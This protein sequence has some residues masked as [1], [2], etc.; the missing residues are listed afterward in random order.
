MAHDRGKI[1]QFARSYTE[2]WC[3]HEV[4]RIA[5]HFAPGGAIVFNGRERVGIEE[6]ANYFVAAF[7]DGEIF[8][9][10]LR[11]ED[12]SVE[13][14]WTLT[15]TRAETG[16]Q[17]RI[18]GYEEWTIGTD[19]LIAESQRHY[20]EAEYERQL[21]HVGLVGGHSGSLAQASDPRA[22]YLEH[23]PRQRRQAADLPAVRSDHG[24][25]GAQRRRD[26]RRRM[27]LPRV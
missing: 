10:D 11:F 14:H 20:D 5:D 12:G 2:A 24:S 9:D 6:V 25:R 15:G 27:G 21:Q 17:V 1:E 3:S 7:P 23:A 16:K 4:G 22:G 13:W 8:M 18:S 19:G 26:Y